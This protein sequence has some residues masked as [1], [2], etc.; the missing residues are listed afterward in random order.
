MALKGERQYANETTVPLFD[1]PRHGLRRAGLRRFEIPSPSLTP[2]SP[3]GGAGSH[4]H[5]RCRSHERRAITN[6]TPHYAGAASPR[7][8]RFRSHFALSPADRR[9]GG[10]VLVIAAA[11]PVASIASRAGKTPGKQRHL[12]STFGS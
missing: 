5:R 11:A 4:G 12:I 2:P 3:R 1:W 7:Q 10:F 9:Y 8:R 6:G